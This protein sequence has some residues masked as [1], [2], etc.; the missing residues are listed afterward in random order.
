MP[1]YSSTRRVNE[2]VER[3][4]ARLDEPNPYDP[5]RRPGT[6]AGILDVVRL[7]FGDREAR[8][9]KINVH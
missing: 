1:V 6:I 7:A 9:V 5:Q 8:R 3:L 2:A 4:I